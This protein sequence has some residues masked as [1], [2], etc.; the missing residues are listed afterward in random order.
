[1]MSD[2][3]KVSVIMPSYNVVKYIDECMKSVLSQTLS[4]IEIICVDAR[5]ED[6]TYEKLE[7]YASENSCIK[8]IQS[9]KRSYGYQMNIG[10]AAAK[11]DY[12][13]IVET[14]DYVA[15]EMFEKLY[16]A[17]LENS[18]DFVKTDFYY[19]IDFQG[20]RLKAPYERDVEGNYNKVISMKKDRSA[21]R[22]PQQNT[23]WSGLY[24]K[25]MILDN[26]IKFNETAGAA[27]QDTG[28][29]LLCT[30]CSDNVMFLN[31]KLYY[32][33]QD[34][35]NASVRNDLGYAKI[36]MEFNWIKEEMVQ[37]G[38]DADEYC[39]ALFGYF[40]LVAYEWNYTRLSEKAAKDFLD[41]I[42]DEKQIEFD[43][44]LMHTEPSW[45]ERVEKLI[46]GDRETIDG[47]IS[48]EEALYPTMR[49][50]LQK[51]KPTIILPAGK[52]A[53]KVME[54]YETLNKDVIVSVAD[55][56]ISKQGK[57][58]NGKV[59]V[60]VEDAIRN[61]PDAEVLIAA[62]DNKVFV[63]QLAHLGVEKSKISVC[64]MAP[65]SGRGALSLIGD[66]NLFY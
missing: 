66:M 38:Y 24:R 65:P 64:C 19:F 51:K 26:N 32:Y 9:E 20:E 2:D 16:I 21:M 46:S 47:Y 54:L 42:K 58:V 1:M 4:D 10:I 52:V 35:S 15:S 27:Y 55:N 53:L 48:Y 3:V 40:R 30:M 25:K 31:D 50:L 59:I 63:E 13:G 22:F 57:I 5:S 62:K 14:D 17:A 45:R 6:G 43:N 11:G 23:I 44:S 8:L 60:S 37:R 39:M 12:I 36:P 18:L 49:L 28:F 7:K 34:N 56:S 33:R 61:H 29:A 41:F